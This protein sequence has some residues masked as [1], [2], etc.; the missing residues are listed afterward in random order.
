VVV[1][2]CC[3]AVLVCEKTTNSCFF[4]FFRENF[5]PLL[6]VLG[7]TNKNKLFFKSSENIVIFGRFFLD[8]DQKKLTRR[9]EFA[10]LRIFFENSFLFFLR[11]ISYRRDRISLTSLISLFSLFS[12]KGVR[13]RRERDEEKEAHLSVLFFSLCISGRFLTRECP[14]SPSPPPRKHVPPHLR[15][16]SVR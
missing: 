10:P 8:Q 6:L 13:K 7:Q 12:A 14:P 1:V 2:I 16:V 5:F 9:D 15:L 4:L 11:H 3:A